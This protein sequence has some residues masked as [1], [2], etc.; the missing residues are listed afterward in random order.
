MA[1]QR[2][3]LHRAAENGDA[4]KVR[5]LLQN[6]TEDLEAKTQGFE[7]TPLHL[8]SSQGH[9]DVVRE[10]LDA[11]AD[12]G[13][14]R[15]GGFTALH[16]AGSEAAAEV[17]LRGGADKDARSSG[18]KT[19]WEQCGGGAA[20]QSFIAA[21]VQESPPVPAPEPEPAPVPVPEPEP[22]PEPAPTASGSGALSDRIADLEAQKAACLAR[23]EY[24][25]CGRLKKEIEALRSQAD[26]TAPPS[27]GDPK[28]LAQQAK[29]AGNKEFKK[30]NYDQAIEHYSAAIAADDSVAAFY[31]N[32]AMCLLRLERWSEAKADALTATER[33][34][35][36][37]KGY[38][39]AAQAC[40]GME[41]Y[42]GM[43]ELLDSAYKLGPSLETWSL[44]CEA[45]EV[46]LKARR[47]EEAV[48]ECCRALELEPVPLLKP[49]RIVFWT[50]LQP[51][52]NLN[53]RCGAGLPA[54]VPDPWRGAGGR[55]RLP[56][57]ADGV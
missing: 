27:A 5:S 29:E 46:A 4:E 49:F 45:A 36:F 16:L 9:A 17:L 44:C 15:S 10:L 12:V 39:R 56:G 31:T 37:A 54:G 8:A 32:R 22:A 21:F 23:E 51:N 42:A 24:E 35:S 47:L 11:G 18:G 43:R 38:L 48:S 33:D 28:E 55:R 30:K 34:S 53:N 52:T 20:V 19:P 26:A 57:R 2:T 14:K 7:E 13:A 3:E 25:E 50:A 6:G 40:G 41:D 1:R